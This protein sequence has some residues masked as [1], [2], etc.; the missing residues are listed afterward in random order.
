MHL[1][2]LEI[3]ITFLVLFLYWKPV[4]YMYSEEQSQKTLQ[5]FTCIISIKFSF[6]DPNMP[7]NPR[8]CSALY[9]RRQAVIYQNRD[10]NS[11]ASAAKPYETSIHMSP[12]RESPWC[13]HDYSEVAY[14]HGNTRND[15]SK[16]SS[17]V[18]WFYFEGHWCTTKQT[19]PK[20]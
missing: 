12:S 18:I 9:C 13:Y 10:G 20:G 2:T 3:K 11:A 19:W 17:K 1:Q 7:G 4:C 6:S 14:S 8:E 15:S 16:R 5:L